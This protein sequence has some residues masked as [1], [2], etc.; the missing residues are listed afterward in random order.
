MVTARMTLDYWEDYVML[1]AVRLIVGNLASRA[2]V[3]ELLKRNT[4][5]EKINA[6]RSLEW[7]K[8]QK[9]KLQMSGTFL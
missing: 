9:A 4:D 6:F 2:E 5:L 7:E 1:E 3:S 8:K